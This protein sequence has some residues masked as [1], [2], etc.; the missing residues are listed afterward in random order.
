MGFSVGFV[1][2]ALSGRWVVLRFLHREAGL[3]SFPAYGLSPGE[4]FF[5]SGRPGKKFPLLKGKKHNP[6][7]AKQGKSTVPDEAMNAPYPLPPFP[8]KQQHC[9]VSYLCGEGDFFVARGF[10]PVPLSSHWQRRYKRSSPFLLTGFYPEV[11]LFLGCR[12]IKSSPYLKEKMCTPL[13][14][15]QQNQRFPAS[16]KTLPFVLEEQKMYQPKWIWA[17]CI[18]V[19]LIFA[20]YKLSICAC[21]TDRIL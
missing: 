14:Q 1:R 20:R 16:V 15:S 13:S 3:F 4:I 12:P 19:N 11:F 17:K 7:G 9:L 10:A 8:A 21:R 5:P 18:S 2:V 6:P